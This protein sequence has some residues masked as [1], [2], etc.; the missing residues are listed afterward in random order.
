MRYWIPSGRQIVKRVLNKCVVCK[1]LEGKP[2]SKPVQAALPDFRVKIAAPFSKVGI[3][4]AGPLLVKVP[5][6]GMSKAYI[7]LF[8]CCV[9]RALHLDLV[10]DLSTQ[11]FLRC[12]R[13]FTARRGVP[14]LI[15]SD[16]AKTFLASDKALR[17]LYNNAK[18]RNELGGK[19]FSG[20][21]I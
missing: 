7:A 3:D 20:G 18:V 19:G 15:V 14:S 13:R 5:S 6:G 2:Y 16:N 11:T 17:K 9:T 8:S 21:S 12:L 1:R 10:S 4:F